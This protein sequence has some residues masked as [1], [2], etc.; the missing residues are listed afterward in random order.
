MI[1]RPAR[2]KLAELVRHL[3]AGTIT[4]DKFSDTAIDIMC[5]SKDQGVKAVFTAADGLY[6]DLNILPYRLRGADKVEPKTRRQMAI[7]ALFLYSD[8]EYEWPEDTFFETPRG[9]TGLA[10]LCGLVAVVGL[11]AGIINPLI[12]IAFLLIAVGIY[13]YSHHYV[14]GNFAEW[15]ERQ[16]QIG[17]FEV[18]PFLRQADF[19]NAK[20]NPRLLTGT[21]PVG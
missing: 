6:G 13:E 9:D 21:E 14:A 19:E 10:L 11:F 7:A 18:W 17:D 20:K 4:T 1:D 15:A 8:L 3:I 16:K 12:T 5:S 2:N